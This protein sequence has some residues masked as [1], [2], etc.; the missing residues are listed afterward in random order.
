MPLPHRLGLL[1]AS[2]V[3]IANMI[4]TGVFTSLGFQME[5]MHSPF[6][7]LMLWVVGGVISLCGA[8]TY[9]ELGSRFPESGG[10]YQLQKNIY[11]PLVGFLSGWVSAVAGFAA[12]TALASIAFGEYVHAAFPGANTQLLALVLVVLFTSIHSFSVRMGSAFQDAFTIVK[13]TAIVAF[14]VAVFIKG[15]NQGLY[16]SP[17]PAAWTEIFSGSFASNLIFVSFA[18][19]GWNAAIY[20][21]GEI[22]DPHKTLPRSLLLGTAL[23]TVLYVLMNA[24]FLFAVPREQLVG[25]VQIGYVVATGLFGE[26]AGDILSVIIAVLMISTVSVMIFIGSRVI[27]KMG[28]DFSSLAFLGRTTTGHVPA[29]A[30]W[31]QGTLTILFIVTSTFDQVLVYSAFS[32]LVN[33]MMTVMG[34]F[35]ARKRNSGQP[36]Y[37]MKL[38][39]VA[40]IVFLII[41]AGVLVF[42][43]QDRPMESLIGLLIVLTGVPFYFLA[44][45]SRRES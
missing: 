30:V 21:V 25:K 16:A 1:S 33:T 23:V 34:I 31:F 35:L 2:S 32:L 18:Y 24:A 37:K 36:E 42:T 13:V 45:R 3:V 41:N 17:N 43:I 22:K 5:G 6:A 4:G 11:H 15:N 40:P 10:E 28:A 20:V 27:N 8:L 26:A 44:R 38:Y 19:T 7:L 29:T 14:I 39:P 12:P 9:A